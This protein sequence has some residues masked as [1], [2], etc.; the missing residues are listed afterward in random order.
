MNRRVTREDWLA[1]A[2]Q[3]LAE[4][5]LAAIAVEPLARRLAVTKGSFYHYFAGSD[6]LVAALLAHWEAVATTRVIA[7]LEAIADPEARL[8][9]LFEVACDQP[10]HLRVEAALIAAAVAGE[11]RVRPVYLRV[12][13]RRLAYTKRLY[14]ALGL[15]AR[16]RER[17]A[18]T[19]YG[20]YLGL[21]QLVALG[22][23]SIGSAAELRAHARHLGQTLLP[24]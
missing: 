9:R 11:P 2:L 15:G 16:E 22:S 8:L 23:R 24:R 13:R 12:N 18:L 17:Y 1:A 7:E 6:E 20:A 14:A 5:G 4:G 21:L 10:D 19:A 3:A